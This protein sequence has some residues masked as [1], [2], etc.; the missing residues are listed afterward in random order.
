M[1]AAD[2][3]YELLSGPY[4]LYNNKYYDK[5]YNY[6]GH[7]RV[8]ATNDTHVNIHYNST[9]RSMMKLTCNS[10]SIVFVSSSSLA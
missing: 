6:H 9:Y 4:Q 1:Q 5:H 3:N 2:K 10:L 7:A 8:T